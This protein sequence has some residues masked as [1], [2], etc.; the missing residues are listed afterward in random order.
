MVL[1]EGCNFIS[2]P[3]LWAT[4]KVLRLFFQK[5]QQRKPLKTTKISPFLKA[6]LT[7][8]QYLTSVLNFECKLEWLVLPRLLKC[9]TFLAKFQTDLLHT[10]FAN[11][12]LTRW[13]TQFK[14][15]WH[16]SSFKFTFYVLLCFC[17]FYHKIANLFD[18]NL[19]FIIRWSIKITLYYCCTP[20]SRRNIRTVI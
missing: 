6:H 12:R 1:K 15:V 8:H 9:A 19:L 20:I 7:E 10:A 17:S 4:N 5:I 14:R 3:L 16:G 2:I 18:E 11:L 13:L